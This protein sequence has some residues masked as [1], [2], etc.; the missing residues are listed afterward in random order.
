MSPYTLEAGK[1]YSL[2]FRAPEGSIT[3]SWN[4]IVTE[5]DS[6]TNAYN[7]GVKFYSSSDSSVTWVNYPT[8]D[9]VDY[10]FE[11]WGE[12]APPEPPSPEGFLE[13][14]GI[15]APTSAHEGDTINFTVH[16][17]NTGGSDYFKIELSGYLTGS[18]EF[19]LGAGLTKNVPF[20]FTMPNHDITSTVTTYHWKEAVGWVWDTSSVW[21]LLFPFMNIQAQP[22]KQ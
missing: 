1:T 11:V 19:S 2:V 12:P 10:M 22:Y 7:N 9:T 18:Q 14:T 15:T 4:W 5:E 20:S 21:E 6:I 16:T 3:P 8:F 13:I 17:K